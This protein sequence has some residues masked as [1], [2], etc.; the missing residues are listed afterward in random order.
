[1]R[2]LV[3]EG[4]RFLPRGTWRPR[5]RNICWR[6]L[7]DADFWFMMPNDSMNG[8]MLN[9]AT[10]RYGQ[11]MLVRSTPIAVDG[12]SAATVYL[13]RLSGGRQTV[14]ILYSD[15]DG[16]PD[17]LRPLGST[18]MIRL[19]PLN[20]KFGARRVNADQIVALYGV[21]GVYRAMPFP[22]LGTKSKVSTRPLRK[23][24]AA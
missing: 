21:C 24:G 6:S 11:I 15:G 14:R 2:P 16:P 19:T 12:A 13:V 17:S 4:P 22:T 18:P 20:G 1:M 9:P 5:G 23:V 3:E 10:I 7:S 8:G